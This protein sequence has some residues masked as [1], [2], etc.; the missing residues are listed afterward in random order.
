MDQSL[1]NSF[2]LEEI[3][4]A[5]TFK[6]RVTQAKVERTVKPA[7]SR[8]RNEIAKYIIFRDEE[9]CNMCGTCVKTCTKGVHILKEG[10]RLFASPKSYKCNGFVCEETEHFCV[11]KCP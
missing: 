2:N 11:A 1:E 5:N 9:K 8:Y 7:P 6:T 10:Y 3:L 4:P